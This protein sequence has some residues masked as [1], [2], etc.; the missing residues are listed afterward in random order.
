MSD[1]LSKTAIPAAAKRS[2]PLCSGET[3]L[4][5]LTAPARRSTGEDLDDAGAKADQHAGLPGAVIGS[6][7]VEDKPA[8]P[9]PQRR[10]DLMRHESEAEQGR[11]IAGA[12]HLGDEAADQRRH[13]EP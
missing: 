8:T 1:N 4:N 3:R 2:T 9:G 13:T 5:D 12:E 10:S 7:H 6:R 11:H